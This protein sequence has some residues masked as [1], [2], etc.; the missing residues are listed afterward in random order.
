MAAIERGNRVVF[1][2]IALGSDGADE[3]SKPLGRIRLELFVKDV[4]SLP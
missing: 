3:K 2:D 4:S 1:F